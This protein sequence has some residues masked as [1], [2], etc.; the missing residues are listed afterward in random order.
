MVDFLS[1]EERFD[2]VKCFKVKVIPYVLEYVND[3]TKDLE[4]KEKRELSSN[5][6]QSLYEF[7][8]G[9]FTEVFG[10]G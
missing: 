9:V 1:P 8:L 4:K 3:L 10:S 5:E 7:Y 6:K 2:N